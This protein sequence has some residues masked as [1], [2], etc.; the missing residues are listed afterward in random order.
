MEMGMHTIV[1]VNHLLTMT[2]V[3]IGR[4]GAVEFKRIMKKVI[5]L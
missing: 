4:E 5:I 3:E 1:A 2:W